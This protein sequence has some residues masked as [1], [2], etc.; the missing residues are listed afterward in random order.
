[1]IGLPYKMARMPENEYQAFVHTAIQHSD[2]G[3]EDSF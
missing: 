2:V 1:M 3:S